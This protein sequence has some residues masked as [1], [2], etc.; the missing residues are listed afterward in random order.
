MTPTHTPTDAL[1]LAQAQ[2]LLL[3]FYAAFDD[4]AS[5]DT[6]ALVEAALSADWCSYSNDKEFKGREAFI[7]G[8][9]GMA[10]MVP[11]MRWRVEEILV[12]GQRAIVRS[13]VSGTP[14]GQFMGMPVSDQ[15]SFSVMAIDIHTIVDGRSA[16]VHHVEDW[17]SAMRQL[18]N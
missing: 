5:K 14:Q 18:K 12:S 13:I 6:R 15:A 10:K 16:V 2:A 8:V 9:Q 3:P 1:S 17:A 7:Q 11:N 4:P